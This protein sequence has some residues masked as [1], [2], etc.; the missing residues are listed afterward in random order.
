VIIVQDATFSLI[1]MWWG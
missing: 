1:C